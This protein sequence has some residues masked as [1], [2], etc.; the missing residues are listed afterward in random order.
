MAGDAMVRFVTFGYKIVYVR[1]SAVTM[2]RSTRAEE[3]GDTAIHCEGEIIRVRVPPDEVHALIGGVLRGTVREEV[4]RS[5]TLGQTTLE[6]EL[7]KTEGQ[8]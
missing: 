1:P 8:A 6:E 5:P 2:I 4:G 7:R 3:M